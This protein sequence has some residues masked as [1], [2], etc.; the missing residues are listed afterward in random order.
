[1]GGGTGQLKCSLCFCI[2]VC[3]VPPVRY[4]RYILYR[5]AVSDINV[6]GYRN[7]DKD[8]LRIN[9]EKRIRFFSEDIGVKSVI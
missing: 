2:I 4:T 8:F 7:K 6:D 1:M 3:F 9:V 5:A